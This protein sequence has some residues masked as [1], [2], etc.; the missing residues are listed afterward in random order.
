MAGIELYTAAFNDHAPIP[1]R[2][3]RDGD[4]I[5]PPLTWSGV[6]DGTAELLLLC[7]DPDAP[8]GTFVHWLVTGI[9]PADGRVDA[10]ETPPG[11]T[12]RTNGFGDAGWGGPQPPV[13]DKAHRYFFHLYA[14]PEPVALPADATA[15]VVHR[16][17]D[18]AQLASGTVVG[19]YH[20]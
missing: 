5:S 9:T 1:K 13:G 14:L 15:E 16:M 11:G 3:A 19:L 6:P 4:N 12:P 2:Y 17:V 10:G 7:E 18:K 20:R 8:S